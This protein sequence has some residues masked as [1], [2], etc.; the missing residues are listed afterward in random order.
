MKHIFIFYFIVI[1]IT[2]FVLNFNTIAYSQ[3]PLPNT[4][5]HNGTGSANK[6]FNIAVASDWGC[7]ENARATAKNIQSEDPQL[8]IAGGDVSY[9]KSASCWF[10][11]IQPFSI[12]VKDS[13]GGQ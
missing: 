2:I 10:E 6:P 1:I 5:N 9:T 4:Q 7:N 12:K 8:V 11:I 13:T 3:E